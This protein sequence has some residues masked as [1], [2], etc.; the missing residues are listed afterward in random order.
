[1]GWEVPQPIRTTGPDDKQQ[2][3]IQAARFNLL[4]IFQQIW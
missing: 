2:R 3:G 1:M 4:D